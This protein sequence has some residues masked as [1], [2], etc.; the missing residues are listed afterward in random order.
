MNPE[1]SAAFV[2][3]PAT[4]TLVEITVYFTDTNRYAV[5]I[6]PFEVPVTRSVPEESILPGALLEAFFDGPTEEEQSQG[7]ESITSGFTGFREIKIQDQIAHVY[8][9]GQCKSMGTTYTVAQPLMR[10]LLQLE[11]IHAV[12]IYDEMGLTEAPLGAGNSVP[13]CLEP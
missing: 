13:P 5:G 10:N 9:T 12:K 8:L 1:A 6:P 7:L 11:E 4:P 3:V 2:E